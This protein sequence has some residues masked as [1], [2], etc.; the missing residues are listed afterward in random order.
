MGATSSQTHI[1]TYIA[2]EY[3]RSMHAPLINLGMGMDVKDKIPD[4][5]YFSA[6]NDSLAFREEPQ[7][8]VGECHQIH[9]LSSAYILCSIFGGMLFISEINKTKPSIDIDVDTSVNDNTYR[10]IHYSLNGG[11]GRTRGLYG[12]LFSLF[13]YSNM[14]RQNSNTFIFCFNLLLSSRLEVVIDVCCFFFLFPSRA[15]NPGERGDHEK[16]INQFRYPFSFSPF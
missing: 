14:S 10:A 1:S 16:S 15:L 4:W 7:A 13:E 6:M 8:R 3:K 9:T 11:G 5:Y 2:H 12:V